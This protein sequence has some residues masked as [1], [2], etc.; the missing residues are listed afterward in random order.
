[1]K[2]TIHPMKPLRTVFHRQRIEKIPTRTSFKK[3]SLIIYHHFE[4]YILIYVHTHSYSEK[5]LPLAHFREGLVNREKPAFSAGFSRLFTLS[6]WP[7]IDRRLSEAKSPSE[8][9]V[10]VD[11][12]GRNDARILPQL[13][14][15]QEFH[16][17]RR[18][19]IRIDP[20]APLEFLASYAL[21]HAADIVTDR[22]LALGNI[23]EYQA[24]L[25]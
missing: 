11:I 24:P 19:L 5:P 10:V 17:E 1:M 16:E 3:S 4:Y 13:R 15:I 2:K 8:V 14:V 7:Y 25:P 9:L 23:E 18:Q 12:V 20:H 22:T 21:Q 6:Y